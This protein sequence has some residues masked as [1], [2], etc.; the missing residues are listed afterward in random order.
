MTFTVEG[1]T[2]TAKVFADEQQIDDGAIS[3]LYDLVNHPVCTNPI[4]VMPDVHPSGD[5][6]V[7]FSMP[8]SERVI[9]KL[10]GGDIGCGMTVW[11]LGEELPLNLEERDKIVR[12]VAP[13][14]GR[15]NSKTDIG[16]D[17]PFTN[18]NTT[19]HR[20]R[21]SYRENFN[22]SINPPYPFE[23]YD[24]DYISELL[25]RVDV[26]LATVSRDVGTLGGGNHFIEF[27]KSRRTGNY[28]LVIHSGSRRLGKRV[29]KYWIERADGHHSLGWL[30]NAE[31]HGYFVDMVF[32]QTYAWWN[33]KLMGEEICDALGI[34][35]IDTFDSPHN[36][37]DFKDLVIRKGASRSHE[38][39]RFAIP[40]DAES[41]VIFCAGIGNSDAN[42]SAPHGAGRV[43]SRSDAKQILSPENFE[44]A[45]GDVYA[46]EI[47]K[48]MVSEA[49]Q[50][51]KDA[52]Y[53][54]NHL[55]GLAE[56]IDV[57][58]PVH[59]VKSN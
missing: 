41:G 20:F 47:S 40:I 17:F 56:P 38:G 27:G 53:V 8:L 49:P 6:L 44:E 35:P 33:R 29:A 18:A 9:P 31:A 3:Q 26:S 23:G 43:L 7:G 32:C 12:D 24:Q 37:I 39:D 55:D 51:Y 46:D 1:S 28:W 15:N 14:R 16:V 58:D 19:L 59:N 48:S 54:L 57:F 36:Y 30:E 34:S 5:V 42:F 21:S 4:R 2:T 50:A 22:Q 11:E 52:D 13:G 10:V 45:V 25:R